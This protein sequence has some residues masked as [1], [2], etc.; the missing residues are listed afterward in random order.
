MYPTGKRQAEGMVTTREAQGRAL[1]DSRQLCVRISVPVCSDSASLTQ[2][3]I[4]CS[5]LDSLT[6]G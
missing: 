6:Q 4:M 1:T 2:D 3:Q 5:D